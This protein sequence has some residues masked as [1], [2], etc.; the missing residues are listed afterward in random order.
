MRR[1]NE[2]SEMYS[3][4]NICNNLNRSNHDCFKQVRIYIKNSLH[5]CIVNFITSINIIIHIPK[6][7]I[8]LSFNYYLIYIWLNN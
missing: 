2:S 6:Y 7:M 1:M 8:L 4:I 3:I 5:K